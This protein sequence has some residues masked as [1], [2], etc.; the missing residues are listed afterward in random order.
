MPRSLENSTSS[1]TERQ[2]KEYQ[3]C[4]ESFDEFSRLFSRD[5]LVKN[6]DQASQLL[7][8]IVSASPEKLMQWAEQI[9]NESYLLAPHIFFKRVFYLTKINEKAGFFA[10][11]AAFSFIKKRKSCP[12]LI[13]SDDYVFQRDPYAH[14][15]AREVRTMYMLEKECPDICGYLTNSLQVKDFKVYQKLQETLI[16]LFLRYKN[17]SGSEVMN[18]LKA[19]AAVLLRDQGLEDRKV[20]EVLAVWAQCHPEELYSFLSNI[21]QLKSLEI[22]NKT[23]VATLV[24]QFG[25]YNFARYSTEFLLRQVETQDTTGHYVLLVYPKYDY[26]GAFMSHQNSIE[27]LMSDLP[28]LPIRVIEVNGVSQ[29]VAQLGRLKKKY[30]KH[31]VAGCIVGAHGTKDDMI[32]GAA[33]STSAAVRGVFTA[34]DAQHPTARLVQEYLAEDSALIFVSCS[35]GQEGGVAQKVSETLDASV[36]APSIPTN[37]AHFS[38]VYNKGALYLGVKYN[39]SGIA[40]VYVSGEDRTNR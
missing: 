16:V 36:I 4:L 35:T 21:R 23:A 28:Q 24:N 39:N 29:L 18:D 20:Q 8:N 3:S 22:I 38:A 12:T 26:N 13:Q 5:A 15:L 34:S 7:I 30:G 40:R 33:S 9:A 31:A 6:H 32:F 17:S 25:L 19:E 14:D 27:M 11:Y 10:Q 37:V 2:T 1:M